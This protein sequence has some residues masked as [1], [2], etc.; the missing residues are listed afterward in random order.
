M[1]KNPDIVSLMLAPLAALS[2]WFEETQVSYTIIGGIAVSFVAQPRLTEDIDATVWLAERDLK[3][4]LEA[5]RAH[6]FTQRFPDT[7]EFAQ[8]RRV[9]LLQHQTPDATI[10]VDIS[11]ATIPFEQEM[12]ERSTHVEVD[13]VRLVFP[14][15]EDLVIMKA[16]AQRPKDITDMA[17][18]LELHPNLDRERVR[19]WVKQFAE[20]LELPEM[21]DDLEHLLQRV[22]TPGKKLPGKKTARKKSQTKR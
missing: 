9:L 11:L 14:T 12:I 10:K 22:P 18:I 8:Q 4:F 20:A 19:Y 13:S 15:P 17:T 6:G 2:R 21:L 5:G 7:L 1:S 16:T 3:T